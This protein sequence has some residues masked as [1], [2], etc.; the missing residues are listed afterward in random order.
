MEIQLHCRILRVSSANSWHQPD[1]VENQRRFLKNKLDDS[2]E[3]I[4]IHEFIEP[5]FNESPIHILND[6]CLMEIFLYLPIADRIRTE[7]GKEKKK[8]SIKNP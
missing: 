5:D 8:I 7:R 1:S 2:D 6:D 3:L 4:K